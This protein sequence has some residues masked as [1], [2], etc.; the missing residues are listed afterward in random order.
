M[1]FVPAFI[2]IFAFIQYPALAEIIDGPANVRD[3]Q[4]STVIISLNDGVFVEA[5]ERPEDWCYIECFAWVRMQ[6]IQSRQ[7]D[8]M[9]L[10]AGAP[11]FDDA[12]VII[13]TASHAVHLPKSNEKGALVEVLVYG[14]THRSNIK[15]ESIP[16]QDFVIQL[17]CEVEPFDQAN[18][19]GFMKRHHF[20][21]W[22]ELDDG[23]S[24][25][26]RYGL[27]LMGSPEPR[28]IFLFQKE[29]LVA[30]LFRRGV[31][32]PERTPDTWD[33]LRIYF[34]GGS[35]KQQTKLKQSLKAS[36]QGSN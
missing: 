28:I 11:L 2:L 36:L 7:Y 23:V 6:D 12:E 5:E 10:K 21:P 34:F 8:E 14:M 17:S 22:Q 9:E 26:I 19:V 31:N 32:L 13:G 1:R 30:A 25:Y 16:E 3:E 4:E 27:G 15:S 20:D 35:R 18:W 33:D 24:V 29:N